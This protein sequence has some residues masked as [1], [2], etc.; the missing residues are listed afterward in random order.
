M[1]ELIIDRTLSEFISVKLSQA[2]VGYD[3]LEKIKDLF[4]LC[5]TVAE[6]NRQVHEKK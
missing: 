3:E 5:S 2:P 6:K 1:Y 4:N